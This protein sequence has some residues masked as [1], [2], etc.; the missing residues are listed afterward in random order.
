MILLILQ[1]IE[2][3]YEK[4]EVY[5]RGEKNIEIPGTEFIQPLSE[6]FRAIFDLIYPVLSP[7][8]DWLVSWLWVTFAFFYTN[9]LFIYLFF[10]IFLVALGVVINIRWSGVTGG[11]PK[12]E[13][14]YEYIPEEYR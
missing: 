1:L 6:F 14:K 12:G 13:K 3:V 9:M 5:D 10:S 4:K 11:A 2:R 8:S 7:L